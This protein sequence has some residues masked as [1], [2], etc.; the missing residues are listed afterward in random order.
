MPSD[1]YAKARAGAAFKRKAQQANEGAQAWEEYQAKSRAVAETTELLRVQRLA[2][3]AQ[4]A[5]R[6]T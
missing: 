4:Q 3:E 2:K 5:S 1:Q 6:S